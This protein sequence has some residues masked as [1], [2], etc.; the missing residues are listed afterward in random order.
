M[1][2]RI[3]TAPVSWGILE[4]A[5]WGW[6]RGYREILDE[7]QQAGYAGT[8]LGPYGFLPTDPAE[9]KAELSRRNMP[10]LGAFVPLPLTDSALHERGL[11][12]ALDVAKLLSA[13]GAEFL[14]LADRMD[15]ARM[16]IAGS[17]TEADG[18]SDAQ[19]KSAAALVTRIAEAAA[20]LG[21]RTVF[22]HHGGTFVETPAELDRLLDSIEASLVGVC[23]DT[24]H[25]WYGGGDPVR[26]AQSHAR[27]IWHLH[28]KDVRQDV[29]DRV[30]RE[31]IPYM[32]AVR[33]GL[34][35]ALGDGAVDI[36]GVT[37]ELEK[38]GFDG[39]AV[40]EQDIDAA[41]GNSDPLASAIRSREYLKSAAGL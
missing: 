27:R 39:W 15:E 17:V 31:K 21:L 1:P 32:D 9:L 19:W 35:C 22:H 13:A 7:M 3:A 4:F 10:L 29:L 14:V 20:I 2:I 28:L 16:R 23:L 34:F 11:N 6:P 36:A 37:R 33:A 40:F 25:Y 8:E 18:M 41:L 12:D 26:F 5:G 38:R 24:G 30:R